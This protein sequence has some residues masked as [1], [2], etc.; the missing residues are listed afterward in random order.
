MNFVVFFLTLLIAAVVSGGPAWKDTNIQRGSGLKI[1]QGGTRNTTSARGNG[2][3]L[4]AGNRASRTT[5]TT[6]APED[7]VHT[8]SIPTS[9]NETPQLHVGMVVPYK[10]FGVR[11][12]TKAATSAK[13]NLQRKLV[14]L[15]KRYDLQVH[16]VMKELTPSPTGTLHFYLLVTVKKQLLRVE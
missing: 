13:Y 2:L 15:F 10:S 14:N 6:V 4:G 12:Y 7:T 1:G 3:K 5:T 16:T 11:E 8:P 9:S